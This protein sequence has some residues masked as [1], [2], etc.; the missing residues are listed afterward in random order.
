MCVSCGMIHRHE[1]A[2]SMQPARR[3]VYRRPGLCLCGSLLSVLKCVE[4]GPECGV[5]S[6]FLKSS[7][8]S[9]I[10]GSVIAITTMATST[11]SSTSL[12][13]R[14]DQ[15]NVACDRC[16]TKKTKVC[17]VVVLVHPFKVMLMATPVR[18]RET[19]LLIMLSSESCVCI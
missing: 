4:S 16:R 18:W 8:Q 14:R 2:F 17:L 19:N 11:P 6:C 5:S 15:V 10:C 7:S 1:D 13:K 12:S 3:H 9:C